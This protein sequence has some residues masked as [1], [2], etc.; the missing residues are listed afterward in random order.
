MVSEVLIYAG[1]GIVA[2]L[3]SGFFGIGGGIIVVPALL[4]IFDHVKNIPASQ[5]MHMAAGTSLAIMIFTSLSSVYAHHKRDVILWEV[6]QRMVGGIILGV[7]C[8]AYLA[9]YLSVVW[10][11]RVLGIF[12]LVVAVKMLTGISVVRSQSFPHPWVN[13]LFSFIIGLK[14]GLLGI[15]GGT[16]VIPYLSWCGIEIRNIA[17]LSALCTMTVGIMGSLIFMLIGLQ[18]PD[19]PALSTGYIYWP[20]VLCAAIPSVLSAP[21]GVK[22][23][24]I[25]PARR[26]IQAFVVILIVMAI[27]LLR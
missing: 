24:D 9:S 25:L 8:G 5:I 22:L 13:R 18:Q 4:M 11:K 19:L 2:G 1:A 7:I 16:L 20:A 21:L 14:S 12:L 10:L 3:M 23:T 17:A 27:H 15:G 26:L 6:Y